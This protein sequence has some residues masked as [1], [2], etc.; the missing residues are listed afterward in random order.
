MSQ[1]STGALAP[2]AAVPA[3]ST[4]AARAPEELAAAPVVPS[5]GDHEEERSA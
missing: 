5:T 3:P 4:P 2:D 1:T